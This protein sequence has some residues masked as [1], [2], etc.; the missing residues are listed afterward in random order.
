M[1]PTLS[2]SRQS[3]FREIRD[4]VYAE[5]LPPDRLPSYDGASDWE[6]IRALFL[7][8][9]S[10]RIGAAMKRT[11]A[12]RDDFKEDRPKLFHPK[13]VC[14]EARWEIA[15]DAGYTGLF[16]RGASVPAIV[17]MSASGNNTSFDPRFPAI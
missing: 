12:D 2:D 10:D 3:S 11:L 7:N 6:T 5:P 14:A 4:R 8:S 17:R 15:S 9:V 13:G 1:Q 16:A